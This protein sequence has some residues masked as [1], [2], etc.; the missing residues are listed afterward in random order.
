[1]VR[2]LS[3][4]AALTMPQGARIPMDTKALKAA[5]KQGPQTGWSSLL[6]GQ[7]TLETLELRASVANGTL[8]I[9]PPAGK[10]ASTPLGVSGSVN[11]AEGEI[12]LLL[13]TGADA[14]SISGGLSAPVLGDARGGPASAKGSERN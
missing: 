5:T 4:K 8:S 6:K 11:L 1:V 3:G 10:P 2:T 7:T 13:G 14:L 9:E 12:D